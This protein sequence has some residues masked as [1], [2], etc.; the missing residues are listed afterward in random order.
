MTLTPA[1]FIDRIKQGLKLDSV[2]GTL[3]QLLHSH[4]LHSPSRNLGQFTKLYPFS[5]EYYPILFVI[6]RDAS[7]FGTSFSRSRICLEVTLRQQLSRTFPK[8][9]PLIL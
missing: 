9:M 8:M 3:F 4:D 1:H 7:I 6:G 2:S 5:V